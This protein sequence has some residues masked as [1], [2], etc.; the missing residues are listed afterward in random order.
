M[1]PQVLSRLGLPPWPAARAATPPVDGTATLS[2]GTGLGLAI[3]ARLLAAQGG[4]LELCPAEPRGTCARCW[5]PLVKS[6]P[7]HPVQPR[8]TTRA[9]W[10]AGSER[11]R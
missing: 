8:R 10:S 11:E 6:T 5:L 1:P 3:V 9:G 7:E 4:R 2:T